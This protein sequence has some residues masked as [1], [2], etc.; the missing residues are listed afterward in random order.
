MRD[1]EYT[2]LLPP[3]LLCAPRVSLTF[4]LRDVIHRA[5][6][7]AVAASAEMAE[8]RSE[9]ARLQ[10]GADRTVAPHLKRNV[11]EGF[12]LACFPPRPRDD[13]HLQNKMRISRERVFYCQS[14]FIFKEQGLHCRF[15]K[16]APRRA[17][18]DV[19]LKARHRAGG[20]DFVAIVHGYQKYL[21]R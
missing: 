2:R 18:F 11:N 8:L 21:F 10:T 17:L 4:F 9:A 7:K 3:P 1:N 15:S 14:S 20:S 5:E 12:V 16:A 13:R 6:A 19:V